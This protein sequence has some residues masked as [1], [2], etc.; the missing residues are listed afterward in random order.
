MGAVQ[1]FKVN[2]DE[3]FTEVKTEGA[4]K[5]KLNSEECYVIVS[6][7]YRKVYFWKGFKSTVRS[8]FIGARVCVDIRRQLG[9]DFSI[10]ALDEGAEHSDFIKLIGGKTEGWFEARIERYIKRDERIDSSKHP[11]GNSHG[12]IVPGRRRIKKY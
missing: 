6:D 4:L 2:V 1:C 11:G 12:W 10:L 5:E 9:V 7:K 8:K 3:T